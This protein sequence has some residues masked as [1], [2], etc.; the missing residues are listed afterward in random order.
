MQNSMRFIGKDRNF[1][2]ICTRFSK[3]RK[4]TDIPLLPLP[5]SQS[6]Q[7]LTKLIRK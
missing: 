1:D 5:A 6:L 2:Y 3:D 7:I 4:T